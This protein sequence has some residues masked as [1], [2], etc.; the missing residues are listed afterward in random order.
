MK[1]K[2]VL[3]ACLQYGESVYPSTNGSDDACESASGSACRYGIYRLYRIVIERSLRVDVGV[4]SCMPRGGGG[5]DVVHTHA[6]FTVKLVSWELGGVEEE[7]GGALSIE[8]KENPLHG[9][10]VQCIVNA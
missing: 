10:H 3:G 7:V 4:G 2:G 8:F 1:V 6:Y 9:W 5:F